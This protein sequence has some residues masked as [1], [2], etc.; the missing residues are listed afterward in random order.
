MKA[1]TYQALG[2]VRGMDVAAPD[3][4]ASGEP[5]VRVDAT[6]ICG[7]GLHINHGRVRVEPQFTI[8][9]EFV[10]T[11]TVTGDSRELAS[12]ARGRPVYE[13]NDPDAGIWTAGLS[14]GLIHDV[15]TCGDLVQRMITEAEAIIGDRLAG[16]RRSSAPD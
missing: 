16:L 3:L 8:G 4:N 6:G 7:S 15:P 10:G 9:H 14:Q 2:E 1:V 13:T 11:V 12:G 5:I